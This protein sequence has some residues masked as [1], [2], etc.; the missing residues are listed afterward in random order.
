MGLNKDVYMREEDRRRNFHIVGASGTGKSKY[1]EYHIRKDIDMGFGLCLIDPSN[2]A[3]TFNAVLEYCA[4]INY[5]KVC[6]IDP[7]MLSDYGKMA[8]INPLD[9]TAPTAS[10]ESVRH[11]INILFNSTNKNTP[12]IQENLKAL[13][14]MLAGQNMT[15]YES[16][17]FTEYDLEKE[18][19]SWIISQAKGVDKRII[20]DKFKTK[21]V[22]KDEFSTTISRLNVFRK[23]PL[24]LML[25]ADKGIDFVKLIDEGWVV[26]CNLYIPGLDEEETSFIGTLLISQINRAME[27]LNEGREKFG[28]KGKKFY[29]YID[30]AGRFMT[31]QIERILSYDRKSG[32]HIILCHHYAGQ[33][34]NTKLREAVNVQAQNKIMFNIPDPGFRLETIKQLGF[35][36][37]MTAQEANHRFGNLPD[38]HFLIKL[39]NNYTVESTTPN[40]EYPDFKGKKHSV[41]EAYIRG[42]LKDPWYLARYE[43]E[44]QIE[45][46]IKP[47][48]NDTKTTSP[49]SSEQRAIPDSRPNSDPP[50][51]RPKSMFDSGSTTE[52]FIRNHQAAKRNGKGQGD[53]V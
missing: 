37:Q 50:K 28:E 15:L 26:L 2:F 11:A 19:W 30:E 10:V 3:A 6:I 51:A 40:V 9:P 18:N 14:R 53:S 8:C 27:I 31:P 23:D 22:W 16:S 4:Y 25:G 49:V 52:E 47:V 21:P 1:L 34:E 39:G 35:G 38:R 7:S 12:R 48:T 17:Y 36:G 33:I 45:A 29:L 46:R 24:N 44:E 41:V 13:F 32:F 5:P 20:N 43:I 42:R